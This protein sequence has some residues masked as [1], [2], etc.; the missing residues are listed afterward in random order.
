MP[1]DFSM[2]DVSRGDFP[3][4]TLEQ[5]VDLNQYLQN[6]PPYTPT[7]KETVQDDARPFRPVHRPPMAVLVVVDDGRDDGERIRVR[8]DSFTI[9]RA[10]G[11]LVIPFDRMM[12][13]EHA[14]LTREIVQDRYRWFLNDLQSSNGTFVRAKSAF[15]SHDQEFM[16]GSSRFRFNSAT[17]GKLMQT[18]AATGDV[19]TQGWQS[20][21]P[22]DLIPSIVELRP[23]GQ[24]GPPQF[25]NEDSILI[26]RGAA[27]QIVV[28]DPMMS[29]QHARLTKDNRDRWVLENL[30][31]ANGLWVRMPRMMI[32]RNGQFLL[33]EQRFIFMVL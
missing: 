24:M 18:P 7:R 33:G 12:S 32:E 25:I 17:Q 16:L 23:D 22:T 27:C 14:K 4:T 2:Q 13:G 26:G 6:A 19:R 30:G 21:K 5:S 29:S 3:A 20:V 8:G 9:G 15:L 28:N 10:K 1:D 11:D 31:A